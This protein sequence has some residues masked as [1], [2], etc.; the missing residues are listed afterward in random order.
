MGGC[1]L[2]CISTWVPI[3]LLF[4]IDR[5]LEISFKVHQR[6][7]GFFSVSLSLPLSPY[8]IEMNSIPIQ[9]SQWKAA[10]V[11]IDHS[12][13]FHEFP[14]CFRTICTN[15]TIVKWIAYTNNSLH[16]RYSV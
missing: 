11:C 14:R 3:T 15:F 5:F 1:C 8:E 12:C 7:R 2:P 9:I 4:I 6:K 16:R 13:G 10:I